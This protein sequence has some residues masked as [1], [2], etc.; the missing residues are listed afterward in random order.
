MVNYWALLVMTKF[1]SLTWASRRMSVQS[2]LVPSIHCMQ[3]PARSALLDCF[4]RSYLCCFR[5]ARNISEML[6]SSLLVI[7]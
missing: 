1:E 4:R 6:L 7:M 3:M 5:L 2:P